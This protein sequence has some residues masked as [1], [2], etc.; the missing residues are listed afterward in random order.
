MTREHVSPI[1]KNPHGDHFLPDL[2]HPSLSKWWRAT[3]H[4]EK[5]NESK[6]HLKINQ[7][8]NNIEAV[9]LLSVFTLALQLGK[10]FDWPLQINYKPAAVAFVYCNYDKF[11]SRKY[12]LVYAADE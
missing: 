6:I 8:R 5:N 3:R 2:L 10:S 4:K 7:S 1:K 9:I 12:L 11:I